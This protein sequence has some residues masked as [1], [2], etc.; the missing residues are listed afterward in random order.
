M[1]LTLWTPQDLL[2]FTWC[3]QPLLPPSAALPA[4]P[5]LYSPTPL[6]GLIVMLVPCLN[7]SFE[8]ILVSGFRCEIRTPS[9]AFLLC[10][11]TNTPVLV[12]LKC[13]KIVISILPPCFSKMCFQ[14]GLSAAFLLA[15]ATCSSPLQNMFFPDSP[16]YLLTISAQRLQEISYPTPVLLHTPSCPVLHG[17][18]LCLLGSSFVFHSSCCCLIQAQ[19]CPGAV[20]AAFHLFLGH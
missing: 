1:L 20:P 14:S 7:S 19:K 16:A 6:T 4:C 3:H 12:M 2:M 10:G 18:Q 17:K 11:L 8:F 9:L 5:P 13:S 15:S